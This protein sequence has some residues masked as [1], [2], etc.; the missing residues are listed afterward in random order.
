MK[1]TFILPVRNGG[2]YL[3]QC[4]KSILAQTY[5]DFSLVVLDN[6]STD[7]GVAWVE[8]LKDPRISI[9]RSE[10]PL[11]IEENWGRV[12]SVPKNEYMTITG[13]DDI[14]EPN[15][16]E[17]MSQLISQHPAASLYQTHF[18]LINGK[19]RRIRKC[20]PMPAEETAAVFLRK[21]LSFLRD[22]F[23]TGYLFR[24][25]DY[26]R[27]GGIPLYPNLMCADDAL[28]LKLLKNS[29]AVTAAAFCFSYRLHKSSVSGGKKWDFM[30]SG[31]EKYLPFLAEY[32]RCDADIRN[33]LQKYLP[34]YMKAHFYWALVSGNSSQIT[35]IKS[36]ILNLSK[37]VCNILDEKSSAKF[38]K[39][40]DLCVLSPLMRICWQSY[41]CWRWLRI[42]ILCL[43]LLP[44][45]SCSAVPG[46]KASAVIRKNGVRTC[47]VLVNYKNYLDTIECL[48]SVLRSN[49]ADYQIVVVDNNSGNDSL[50]HIVDWAENT[51][52][53]QV[54]PIEPLS[55][56]FSTSLIKPIPYA[57]YDKDF[58]EF[59]SIGDSGCK[60]VLIQSKVN[61]G[62]SGG[63]NVAITCALKKNCFDYFWLLNNDTVVEPDTLTNLTAK[64]DKYKA[65][66]K[67]VGIMGC[68][69]FRYSAPDSFQAIGGTYN[70]RLALMRHIGAFQ[71]DNGQFDIEETVAKMD[72]VIGASMFIP[73]GFISDVGLLDEQYFLY[74]E[75]IDWVIRGK[76]KGWAIG[77]CWDA[78][79][80]HKE[81]AATGSS[82]FNGNATKL[83][84]YF[85]IR[86]RILITRKF[87]KRYLPLVY[88]GFVVTMFNRVLRLQFDRIKMLLDIIIET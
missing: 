76:S 45:A 12:M 1:F 16:L 43:N 63:N 28:W 57:L 73:A 67:K 33:V 78:K 29:Y 52:S 54:K 40:V 24:S 23:G 8:S 59:T 17:V 36:R 68:K 48:E 69:L 3:H 49:I 62:F 41:R 37:L 25:A 81:G 44:L 75:E 77:F 61:L 7:E 65:E 53:V 79:V 11:T 55:Y 85:S 6:A 70:K 47:I 22:S 80:Y 58:S 15:Y 5:P 82:R 42:Q 27:V 83:S 20:I 13:H 32:I 2:Q 66:F 9:I 26:E 35:A 72:Y 14:F 60:L 10:V 30:F 39:S 84:D 56:L 21:R 31:L 64:A 50:R 38:V 51:N 18:W 34:E 19:G 87:Y 88:M 71:K 46:V 74:Y 4:V 86:N